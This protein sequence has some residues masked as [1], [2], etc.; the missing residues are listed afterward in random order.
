MSLIPGCC[1]RWK[2]KILAAP[3]VVELSL[4][5]GKKISEE[6]LVSATF[7][8][9]RLSCFPQ[10]YDEEAH[11]SFASFLLIGVVR[12]LDTPLINEA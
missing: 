6:F 7:L 4:G 10:K 11:L 8:W 1:I 9:H 12:H 5:I 2:E 3:Y